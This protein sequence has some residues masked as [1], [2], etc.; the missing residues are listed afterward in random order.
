MSLSTFLRWS[1][2]NTEIGSSGVDPLYSESTIVCLVCSLSDVIIHH[3][4]CYPSTSG[5]FKAIPILA[6]RYSK[7]FCIVKC[8]CVIWDHHRGQC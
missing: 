8:F 2:H 3:Q 6:T 4:K 7:V 1:F 5:V